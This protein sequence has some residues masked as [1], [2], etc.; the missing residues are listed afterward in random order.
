MDRELLDR[1]EFLEQGPRDQDADAAD[2]SD[3]E[4]GKADKSSVDNNPSEILHGLW[5]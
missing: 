1:Q 2:S 3:S 5:L 4:K